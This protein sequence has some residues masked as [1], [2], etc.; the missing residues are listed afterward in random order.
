M[1]PPR[2]PLCHTPLRPDDDAAKPWRPFCSERCQQLDLARW[3]DGDYAI[4][5]PAVDP[6]AVD[7]DRDE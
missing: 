2:C 3:L 1:K 6:I 7:P 5:G 4:P